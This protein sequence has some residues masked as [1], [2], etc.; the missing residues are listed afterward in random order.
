MEDAQ[1]SDKRDGIG[2]AFN[3]ALETALVSAIEGV[4]GV[5]SEGAPKSALPD[6]YK[7]L[8]EGSFS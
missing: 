3:G 1:E 5:R 8:P 6:I 2:V 7:D 4:L